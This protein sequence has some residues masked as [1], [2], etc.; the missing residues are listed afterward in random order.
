MVW[1]VKHADTKN[2]PQINE[3][4]QGFSKKT[5]FQKN[6]TKEVTSNPKQC[7]TIGS[8]VPNFPNEFRILLSIDR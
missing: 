2:T 8:G 1:E 7:I 6:S 4:Q 5:F 3:N